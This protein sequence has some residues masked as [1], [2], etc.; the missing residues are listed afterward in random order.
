MAQRNV[1]LIFRDLTD[2]T[3]EFFTAKT[4]PHMPESWSIDSS[5]AYEYLESQA[6]Y[7][8]REYVTAQTTGTSIDV[9]S[10][11]R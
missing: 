5:R 10:T 2:G 4:W 1:W 11:T 9:M 6:A 8:Q 7:S 3:R